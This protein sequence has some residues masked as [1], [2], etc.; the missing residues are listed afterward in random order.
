MSMTH[1]MYHFPLDNLY[2]RFGD[3]VY[4]QV[5]GI[6]MGTNF[7]PLVVDLLLYCYERDVMLSL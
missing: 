3:A 6:P 1:Y 5:L 7:A 4:R 2:V